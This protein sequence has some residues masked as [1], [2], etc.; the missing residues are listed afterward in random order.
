VPCLLKQRTPT[1][2]GVIT[3]THNEALRGVAATSDRVLEHLDRTSRGHEYVYGV[4]IQGDLSGSGPWPLEAWQCFFLWPDTSAPFLR[5]VSTRRRIGLNCINFIP[6]EDQ[7]EP[8]NRRDHDLCVVTRPTSIKRATETLHVM[9]AL[10]DL[11][12]ARRF[13]VVAPDFRDPALGDRS[14]EAFGIDRAFYE[15]PLKLFSAHEL[16][17][18]SF[19]SSSVISFGRMPL[20]PGLLLDLIAK[21]RFLYLASHSEGTP[22]AIAE[23][24][25]VGT[26]CVISESLRSPVRT[27]LGDTN[28]I[29]VDDDP[30][31]AA[32]AIDAALRDY[33]RFRVDVAQ[34]RAVFGASSNT[35]RLRDALST[36][37]T[38]DGLR[39]DGDWYLDDLHVRLACHGQK[40]DP[41]LMSGEER[42][43]GWLTA[44][45]RDPYDE[46]AVNAAIGMS[47]W[48][49][50]PVHPTVLQRALAPLRRWKS[51]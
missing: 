28:S 6:D 45:E 8:V 44:S 25:L 4:H 46:D 43:F 50:P 16:K 27:H 32:A 26:P 24:L 21:S 22:R 12:P 19:V 33:N 3:F 14:Y 51:A 39:D 41:Q 42:F 18:I 47:D 7:S 20:S 9:R 5:Q 30:A 10:L 36:L 34:A 31:T 40:A 49:R 2:P 37:L 13:V 38:E 11:D 23:A 29:A 48:R 17:N 1:S 35:P 15:L